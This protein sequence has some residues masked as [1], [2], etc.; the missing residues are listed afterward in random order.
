V[1]DAAFA[2]ARAEQAALALLVTTSRHVALGQG[3]GAALGTTADPRR[4]TDSH[5]QQREAQR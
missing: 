2:E 3:T 4:T 1:S 5:G